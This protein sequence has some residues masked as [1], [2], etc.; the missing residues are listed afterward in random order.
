LAIIY[1]VAWVDRQGR[2]SP[3]IEEPG[4]YVN[5]RISPDG[6]R[7]ALTQLRDDNWDVWIYDLG[8]GVTT[9]LTFDPGVESEQIWSSD[10]KY[11]IFSSDREGPDSLYRKRA[12]G[13]GDLERLTEAKIPQWP[14]SWSRD[15]RYVAAMQSEAQYDLHYVDLSTG[16]TKPFV[17]TQF[18]EGFGAI[19]PD[20]HFLAYSSNE[21]GVYQIYVRPFPSGEAKWQVSEALGTAPRWRGDGRELFWRNDE[22]IVAAPVQID[23]AIFSAGKPQQLFKGPWKGGINGIGAGGLSFADYDVTQD[24]QR[25]VMFPDVQDDKRSH[26]HLTLRTRWFDELEATARL[27]SVSSTQ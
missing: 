9:R 16:E 1:P 25:F 22:G 20:G 18:G 7:L 8:R 5:P 4:I 6:S 2:S 10:G 19:S 24:G 3:L 15:G 14:T 21:S 27:G 13:S 17:S 26:Q 12:D 11:L 23:G